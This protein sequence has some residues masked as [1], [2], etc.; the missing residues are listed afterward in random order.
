M[1]QSIDD[2]VAVAQTYYLSARRVR[3]EGSGN[4]GIML[5]AAVI[6][7][8]IG[9]VD[10]VESGRRTRMG[11]GL[12]FRPARG[13]IAPRRVL[14]TD[15]RIEG[16]YRAGACFVATKGDVYLERVTVHN[17]RAAC[18]ALEEGGTF[19]NSEPV[20]LGNK[21]YEKM[22]NRALP[23][24]QANGEGCMQG[25]LF[26]EVCCPIHCAFCG[27]EGCGALASDGACCASEIRA[28]ER[29]CGKKKPPCVVAEGGGK[30]GEML[31]W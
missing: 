22:V 15:T 23:V 2:G 26:G 16:A 12:S 25:L 13:L 8:D 30:S 4:N 28:M 5:S 7:A 21:T 27:G 31:V 29:V 19:N 18:Y 24:P 6:Y 11:C 3:V 1:R 10:I 17:Q 14:V 20:C 9:Q